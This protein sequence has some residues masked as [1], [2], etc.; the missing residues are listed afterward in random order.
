MVVMRLLLILIFIIVSGCSDFSK[1]ETG[2]ENNK[3]FETEACRDGLLCV[4]NVC[5]NPL[6][7]EDIYDMVTISGGDFWMGC[8]QLVDENCLENEKPYHKVF[9]DPFRIDRY[10]VT[11]SQYKKCVK[12]GVCTIP[13]M[14]NIDYCNYDV[15]GKES[16]PMNC[17]DWENA[18]NYCSW[19]GKDLPTEA[20][21][22][23]AA[24]GVDGRIYPWGNETITCEYDVMGEKQNGCEP[25]KILKDVY[26]SDGSDEEKF[27]YGCK[28]NSTWVSGSKKRSSSPYGALNMAGNVSEWVKDWYKSNYY[29]SSPASNPEGPDTGTEKVV[30]GGSWLDTCEYDF[31]VSNR[32]SALEPRSQIGFRCVEKSDEEE[33]ND[34]SDNDYPDENDDD[35]P[36]NDSSD[37]YIDEKNET[38]DE[39]S[40]ELSDEDAGDT[41]DTGD[42]GNTGD[43]GDSGNT[44]DT[45]D[46][47]NTGN[48]GNTGD[49]GNSGIPEGFA[50]ISAGSFW[51]GSPD[52]ELGR[53]AAMETLH[54]VQLTKSFYMGKYEVTQGE[55]NTVMGYSPSYFLNCG[56][57]CPVEQVNWHEA[58]KYAN[59]ISKLESLPECFEC[60]G[61]KPD[62]TCSLKT[63]YSKPQD[64]L[65]YRLPT[66]SE[67]EYAARAG[68]DTA[69]YNGDITQTDYSPL[70]PNLD[71]IGWYGGNSSSK[72]HIVGGKL[73]NA[74]G[75]YDMSGN[76]W[77]W[78][79][80]WYQEAYPTG[81]ET[82]PVVD[83]YGPGSGSR[84][85]VRGGSR[86]DPSRNC[87]SADRSYCPP[88][89]RYS[90][91]GFRLARTVPVPQM[92]LIP[93]G[94][95]WMGSPDTELGRETA[96][97]TL[98]Y[99][100]L[101]KSFY[102]GKYEVT[103]SE[104]NTV[105]GYNSSCFLNC[106]NN[107][108]VEQVNWHE[109]AK[110]ANELS[111][112]ES[113][114]ECF[115]CTGAAPDFTCS[116]KSEYS[117]PQ[118]C[119]GYRLPT[120]SEWEYAARGGTD[121][122]FYNGDITQTGRS[123]LDPN[124]DAIGWYGGNS[125]V[126]YA[127]GDDCST[128]FTGA[129]TC[130]THLV[131]GKLA[132]SFGLYD[133]SG[134]VWELTYDCYQESYPA[135]DEITP[136][137]DPYGLGS[138]SARVSRGGAWY[139]LSQY[140]RSAD[141]N[142]ITLTSRYCNHGFRLART[143]EL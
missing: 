23:K 63:T 65:G 114:P 11:V 53:T 64:C 41:G 106:G 107:C 72:T 29:S 99:V 35:Y 59:E 83:P 90:Y 75:L 61:T 100:Q 76:V 1:S 4:D 57:N 93:A 125:S 68:T 105:M 51:M 44:G 112:L 18:L 120:E 60:S 25:L 137:V 10:E 46:T 88:T 94:S 108:P 79:Y 119:L 139:G 9:L 66:E 111:K 133:M 84:R 117:K 17:V 56:N 126:S 5:I 104:F 36:D 55:F 113:L 132:N 129:T 110:Y 127:G 98:H 130:G 81:D 28:H 49:T 22:E 52:T 62:F 109:A 116:L 50:L 12:A 39:E 78:S 20:Q 70:D 143:K 131:G 43:T 121:T 30:R 38:D 123:S 122:A 26:D 33:E 31:R 37:E 80:D 97:E 54:Y 71:E 48:T 8:N 96:K 103:Q 21:W 89:D 87:R 34:D 102:M 142:W 14:G 118:D 69:F 124:L 24:R 82:T 3:C 135:G 40:D 128:W 134:N 13:A 140:C 138:N 85:V 45:G 92:V 86:D 16:H 2:L 58:A 91:H 95:F 73:P 42:S 101:T 15:K 141:R 74:F 115:D 67:W 47:G 27:S 32:R 136:V 77:E 6:K 7:K 19:A